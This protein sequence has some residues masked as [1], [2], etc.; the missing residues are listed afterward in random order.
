VTIVSWSIPGADAQPILGD[1]HIPSG[2]ARGV[3][4]IAH[5]FKGYKDYGMLPRIARECAAAG[6]IAHRFNFSH[7]GMTNST[8]TFERPDLFERDTWSKQ[9]F[10]LTAVIEAIARGELAGAGVPLF[11]L[12]HSR[13]GIVALLTAADLT[14]LKSIP[15]LPANRSDRRSTGTQARLPQSHSRAQLGG[16]ITVAAPVSCNPFTP[17]QQQELLE[18]GWIESPSSR[19]GQRLRVGRA[20]LQEQLDD[21]A[22]HDVLAHAARTDCPILVIHG[23]RDEA[24]DPANAASIAAAAGDRAMLRIIPGGDHVFN[25]PNPLPDDEPSSPQLQTMIECLLGFL[26]PGGDVASAAS[27][28]RRKVL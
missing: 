24:V 2:A 10:D 21:P 20:F 26:Q 19:T 6:F 12:G 13:G 15:D 25:T 23:D 14:Y 3:I 27:T 28:S 17:E 1:A 22:R 4:A 8:A 11:V 16:V 9:I 18:N 7:S 5:G